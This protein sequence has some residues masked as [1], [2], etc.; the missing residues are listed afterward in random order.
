MRTVIR[1]TKKI[2]SQFESYFSILAL[3]HLKKKKKEE[4]E[5]K[6]RA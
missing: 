4:E 2:K 5:K 6:E 3:R 1:Q